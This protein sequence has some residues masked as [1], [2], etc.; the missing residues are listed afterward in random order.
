MVFSLGPESFGNLL[1]LFERVLMLGSG[2]GNVFWISLLILAPHFE[3]KFSPNL[4]SR[5]QFEQ[6]EICLPPHLA[7]FIQL[8][9]LL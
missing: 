2:D 3:Q 7:F 1:V 4:C 6:N 8:I 9:R 5:P